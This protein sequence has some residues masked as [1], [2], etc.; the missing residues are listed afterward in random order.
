MFSWLAGNR[1]NM[2]RAAEKWFFLRTSG[3]GNQFGTSDCDEMVEWGAKSWKGIV[4]NGKTGWHMAVIVSLNS[5][6]DYNLEID[7]SVSFRVLVKRS[8]L[9]RLFFYQIHLLN[10]RIIILLFTYFFRMNKLRS[11]HI[12]RQYNLSTKIL[13]HWSKIF[14]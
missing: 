4:V 2:F 12:C 11:I 14:G 10:V 7:F 5:L 3:T 1:F 13:P 6:W 8:M 9:R